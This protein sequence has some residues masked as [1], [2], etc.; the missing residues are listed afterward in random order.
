MCRDEEIAMQIKPPIEIVLC[1]SQRQTTNERLNCE[2]DG[3]FYLSSY[4]FPISLCLFHRDFA[5]RSFPLNS[6]LT[7]STLS[8]GGLNDPNQIL[9]VIELSEYFPLRNMF[10]SYQEIKKSET[11][12]IKRGLQSRGF[13]HPKKEKI[14]SL[15]I[16]LFFP[17]LISH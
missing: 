11:F 9:N 8:F 2:F 3:K 7:P 6:F 1:F 4:E 13:V 14:N 5:F 17:F 10:K 15:K 16:K 12:L